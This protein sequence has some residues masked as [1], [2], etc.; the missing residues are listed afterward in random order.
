MERSLVQSAYSPASDCGRVLENFAKVAPSHGGSTL[1]GTVL[2]CE[3]VFGILESLPENVGGLRQR[4]VWANESL[5]CID[6]S[7]T[8]TRA[9][10][11]QQAKCR[12]VLS[13][14]AEFGCLAAMSV[15]SRDDFVEVGQAYLA[16]LHPKAARIYL[17]T[18]EQFELLERVVRAL[19]AGRAVVTRLS[20][21]NRFT[22]EGGEERKEIT[23]K[24]TRRSLEA[25]R[26]L[27]EEEADFLTRIRMHV[28]IKGK[29]ADGARVPARE[30]IFG[31]TRE[32]DFLCRGSVQE[33][34]SCLLAGA[35]PKIARELKL[36]AH[37]GREASK[38][39]S[40]R[41]LAIQFPSSV[42]SSPSVN[43]TL[44]DAIRDL[45]KVSLSV[46][47]ANPYIHAAVLDH[48]DGSVTDVWVLSGN[49][50]ILVPQVRCTFASLERLC[51]HI[52]DA[53]REG[54][55]TDWGLGQHD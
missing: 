51:C 37:R 46:Y 54:A 3:D 12:M 10:R 11:K 43:K 49:R 33:I 50:I 22:E 5:C 28:R 21:F 4:A 14:S 6:T 47:H 30:A 48:M 26:K 15:D 8:V 32:G 1:R 41:P 23:R 31:I 34:V 24:S 42:F 27:F 35:G 44:L 53:F 36:F 38:T 9:G 7:R 29:S 45:S 18:A 20:Y 17:S 19:G 40:P 55:V 52:R 39:L 25:A 2:A 13:S 16:K